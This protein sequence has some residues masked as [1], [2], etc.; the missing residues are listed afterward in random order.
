MTNIGIIGAGVSGLHLG[1]HLRAQDLPV[2]IYANKT[3]D[4]IAN[5]PVQNSV[6]HMHVTRSL[7]KELGIDH[8][9]AEDVEYIRHWHYNGWG[10]ERTFVGDFTKPSGVVDYRIYLPQL[11]RDFEE[12]GGVIEYQQHTREMI[13]S[14]TDVHD[15]VVVAAGKGEISEMFPKREDKSPYDAPQRNL[16]VGFWKGVR[17]REPNGVEISV[18][19]GVG[20]LLA[21]PMWSFS[22]KVLALL[23]ESVPGGPQAILT[24]QKYSDGPEDYRAK[25]LQMLEEYHPTVFERVNLD[26]FELQGPIDILQGSV[27]PVF[28]EDFVELPNGKFLLA[29][30]DFH[31]TLDPVQAQGANSGAY[32]AKIIAETIR[33]DKV[34]DRRFMEKVARRR[35]ERLEGSNDWINTMI[36][37]GGA[38]Q[39]PTL[40]SAMVHDR[41]LAERFTENFNY[42]IEQVDLLGTPERVDAAIAE[43]PGGE[44]THYSYAWKKD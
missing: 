22:G 44:Q 33:E 3:A 42:P 34:F 28:R 31:L 30:G 16:A 10:D 4:E 35:A 15:L 23:F 6:A 5:G 39:I 24:E 38:E 1:L 2:T 27:K 9:R 21:I 36:K 25:T 12:R 26:E 32:S 11:M 7:E 14:L 19:P 41:A 40:F 8:W 29:L 37:P 13:E 18:V 20:E 43:S 17:R